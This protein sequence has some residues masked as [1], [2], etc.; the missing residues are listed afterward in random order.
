MGGV[1]APVVVQHDDRTPTGSRRTSFFTRG[2]LGPE[3]WPI[4]MRWSRRLVERFS[5]AASLVED[6]IG[7]WRF[8][9]WMFDRA[10]SAARQV[11]APP[12][13]D[14]AGLRALATLLEDVAPASGTPRK[15]RFER[16]IGLSR[17]ESARC[18]CR[19]SSPRISSIC[20]PIRTMSR[21]RGPRNGRRCPPRRAGR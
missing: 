21:R 17:R 9:P 4:F 6:P 8:Q 2:I 7:G 13:V 14:I 3:A 15:A 16:S 20:S 12:H 1:G 19:A 5:V 11:G 18:P 10:A